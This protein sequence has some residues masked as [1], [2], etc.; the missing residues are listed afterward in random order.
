MLLFF[1]VVAVVFLLV[2]LAEI[3]WHHHDL[4]P[5]YTRKFVHITVGTFVAFWPFI[6]SPLEIALLSLAFV[7]VVGASNKFGVFKAMTRR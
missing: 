6:L 7:S 2:V 1:L 5:E 3:L 4:D